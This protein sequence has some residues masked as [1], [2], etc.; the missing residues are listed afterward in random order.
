MEIKTKFN[1]GEDVFA[2]VYD[3]VVICRWSIID[4]HISEI[5]IIENIGLVY[6]DLS[7]GKIFNR[8]KEE[9][10]FA[11]QAEAQAEC[12]RRNNG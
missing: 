4:F 10:C 1:V 8:F 6:E 12:D 5:K 9:D 3:D 2:L 7:I 11:T